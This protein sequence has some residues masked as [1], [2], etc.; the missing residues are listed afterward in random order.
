MIQSPVFQILQALPPATL[1]ALDKFI[2]SPYHV[3]HAGVTAL[4]EYLRAQPAGDPG[5]TLHKETVAKQL[6]ETPER[7]YHLTS[8]L[9]EAVE[10][11]LAL[12]TWRQHPRESHALVVEALRRLQ[13][14]DL[15]ATML[16][17]ARKR[18]QADPYRGS[19]Y[20]RADFALHLEAYH[21][22]QQQG[23]AKIFN[24]QELS[25]AQDVA[26]V[27]EKL[28]T[29]C[30]LLSHQ[31]V[32]KKEYD[33]GLLNQVLQFLD[34][35]PYLQIPSVAAYYHGYY[36]L[37]GATGSDAHFRLLKNILEQHPV[38]FSVAEVHD[39]YLMAINFC[40]RRINQSE[41]SYFRHVFDLYQSGLE[42]GALLEGGALSRWTYNNI[43]IAALKLREFD[44]TFRFLN[45]YAALLPEMHREGALNFNLAR[46]YYDT[47][48]Y[49][50]AMQHLVRMEYDDV[51]QNLVAKTLLCKIYYELDEY[52]ALENQ[53]DSIE[54]YLRR[55]KV[56]GYHKENYTAIV[57]LMRKLLSIDANN[58]A[59][60]KVILQQV[61]AAPGLSE[62][63]WF[64]KQLAR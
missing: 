14:D 8:Y 59:Q 19:G 23:R 24:L 7:L 22:S 12:E 39:L 60:K 50:Q 40:I 17:Y 25:E 36:A 62:R 57:R 38:Q 64:L 49:R 16:R 63:D 9:L 26:F 41:E 52:D 3:T 6:G 35:H 34:G 31:A 15:S 53:L 5:K 20:H 28:R 58:T 2:A 55:K 4:Y 45:D 43:A 13:L 61:E 44:W 47:G 42:H 32:S 54:I 46:Y 51:L 37:A 56:L 1:R 30:M 10:Q 29:G 21:L 18:L 27:C 48:N 11:F 33:K